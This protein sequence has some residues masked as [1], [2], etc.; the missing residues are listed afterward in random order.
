M[1]EQVTVNHRVPGSSPGRGAIFK[2]ANDVFFEKYAFDYFC[3]I[4]SVEEQ[5]LY[6][7][8]VGS[9]TLSSRTSLGT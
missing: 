1:V 2:Y 7:E 3:G 6:T 4:S 5:L 8:K 9:S